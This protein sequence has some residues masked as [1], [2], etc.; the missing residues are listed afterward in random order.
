M[1]N[2]ICLEEYILGLQ[3]YTF[4]DGPLLIDKGDK[5]K[6]LVY[7][8]PKLEAFNNTDVPVPVDSEKCSYTISGNNI[9]GFIVTVNVTKDPENS[10]LAKAKTSWS[11]DNSSLIIKDFEDY[12]SE[13]DPFVDTSTDTEDDWQSDTYWDDTEDG[14]TEYDDYYEDDYYDNEYEEDSYYDEDY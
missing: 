4:E 7:Y 11:C 12:D 8:V 5:G 6:W 2:K 10:L 1:D 3:K 13:K 9:G 14:N